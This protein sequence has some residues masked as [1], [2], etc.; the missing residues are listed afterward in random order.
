MTL[1]MWFSFNYVLFRQNLETVSSYKILLFLL[2]M[3]IDEAGVTYK[4]G[5]ARRNRRDYKKN[6]NGVENLKKG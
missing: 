1:L 2:L 3:M 5:G 4:W 6:N